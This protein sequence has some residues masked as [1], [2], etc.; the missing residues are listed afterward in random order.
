MGDTTPISGQVVLWTCRSTWKLLAKH[1]IL[2]VHTS[3]QRRMDFK[4]DQSTPH[5]YPLT[6]QQVEDTIQTFI[7][8]ID[9]TAVCDLASKHNGGRPCRVIDQRN[10]SFNICF[11]VLFEDKNVTWVL[12]I[13][14]GPVTTN[15]WAKIASEV[16]TTRCA[17]SIFTYNCG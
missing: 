3:G 11:F 14:I 15:A 4:V 1:F 5:A 17:T 6:A 10:G 16:A 13:P 8:S 7:N 12:R 2:H 9:K